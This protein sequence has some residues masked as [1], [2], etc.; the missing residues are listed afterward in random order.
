MRKIRDRKERKN[1]GMYSFVNRTVKNWNKLL[2]EELGTFPCKSKIF[3]KSV[4]K[5]I[6][7]GMKRKEE[8]CGENRL[9]VQ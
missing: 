7:S 9:K 2:T 6:I 1:I 4:R 5:A 3:R 8:K